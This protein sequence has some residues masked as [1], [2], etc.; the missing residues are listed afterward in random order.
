MSSAVDKA[1]YITVIVLGVG[2]WWFWNNLPEPD[3]E[4]VAKMEA[5]RAEEKR[6]GLHCMSKVDGAPMIFSVEVKFSEND[7]KSFRHVS[8]RIWPA[9]DDGLHPV[10]MTYL[11]KNRFGG[12][13]RKLAVGTVSNEGCEPVIHAVKVIG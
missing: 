5:Q 7:R 11:A 12:M 9:G 4:H 2:G 1:T 13:D 3:P 10:E 6:K 8:S